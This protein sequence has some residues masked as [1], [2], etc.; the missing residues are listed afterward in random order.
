[1]EYDAE[2]ATLVGEEGKKRNRVEME[3]TIF[4]TSASAKRLTDLEQ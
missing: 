4:L 1:M 3:D 2:D